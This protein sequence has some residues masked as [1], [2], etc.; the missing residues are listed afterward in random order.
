MKKTIQIGII[1]LISILNFSC[2]ENFEVSPKYTDFENDLEQNNL[3]DKVKSVELR[4]ANV[5]NEKIEDY[6]LVSK[7][8]YSENGDIIYQ[9][10]YDNFGKLKQWT[11]M[12]MKMG[13]KLKQFLKI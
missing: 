1:I 9:E 8:N 11:K 2:S 3:F 12:N 5:F 13:I 4:K 6:I 7:E 10:F